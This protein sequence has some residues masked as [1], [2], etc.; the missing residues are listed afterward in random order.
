MVL[1]FLFKNCVFKDCVLTTYARNINSFHEKG[2]G[3][4]TT[5]T[6]SY[7]DP[8][9]LAGGTQGRLDVGIGGQEDSQTPGVLGRPC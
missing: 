2:Q 3:Q 8:N 1:D 9:S 5:R 6:S 4:P 7:D